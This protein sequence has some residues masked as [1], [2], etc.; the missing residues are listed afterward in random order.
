MFSVAINN[1]GQ[2]NV[3][4]E[5]IGFKLPNDVM[6]FFT[7]TSGF[8]VILPQLPHELHDGKSISLL[9]ERKILANSIIEQ[10]LTGK[11]RVK[12]FCKDSIGNTYYSRKF[13]IDLNQV[14]SVE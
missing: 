6:L 5:T 12:G 7:R 10:K 1:V 9:V 13:P 11:V 14:L 4:I 3:T 8:D 2:R